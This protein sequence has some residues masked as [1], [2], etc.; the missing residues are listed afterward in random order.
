MPAPRPTVFRVDKFHVPESSRR[1]FIARLRAVHA[2]LDQSDGCLQNHV[3]EQVSGSG[4]Y[5]VVT[6]VEWRDEASYAAAREAAAARYRAEGA[7]PQAILADLG[8]DADLGIYHAVGVQL[9][10]RA[11]PADAPTS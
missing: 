2:F 3:L 10:H 11:G 6:L 5:N 9:D 7:E 1:A 8:I 4:R